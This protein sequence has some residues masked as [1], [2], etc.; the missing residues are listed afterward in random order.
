[1]AKH[2]RKTSSRSN[3]LY[4]YES[5]KLDAVHAYKL[6]N[7]NE[8]IQ[9]DSL[10]CQRGRVT[11]SI[12]DNAPEFD[13]L[14]RGQSVLLFGLAAPPRF[15]ELDW[16]FFANCDRILLLYWMLEIPITSI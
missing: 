1:M 11:L 9:S 8:T 5:S 15:D 2:Q 16:V 7:G 13:A 3:K 12:I 14:E 4:S 10:R 6:T